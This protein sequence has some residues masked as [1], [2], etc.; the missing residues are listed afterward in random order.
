[1]EGTEDVEV[2]EEEAVA[3]GEEDVKDAEELSTPSPGFSVEPLV[4]LYGNTP[5]SALPR[6]PSDC[7]E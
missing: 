1:M 7:N 3:E 5:C 6:T 2:T 4:P